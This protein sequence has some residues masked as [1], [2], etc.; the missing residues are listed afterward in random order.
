[1]P[2][3]DDRDNVNFGLNSGL[4]LIL[5]GFQSDNFTIRSS[6]L[7]GDSNMVCFFFGPNLVMGLILKI[8]RSSGTQECVSC[9]RRSLSK[10]QYTCSIFRRAD[11]F[12]TRKSVA[13]SGR[14]CRHRL[15]LA[16]VERH[17]V[18]PKYFGNGLYWLSLVFDQ[19]ELPL[20]SPVDSSVSV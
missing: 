16:N 8:D 3:P 1:M 12:T 19:A 6:R 7:A 18:T 10:Y 9:H 15:A 5:A 2:D 20:Q 11:G 17:G 13:A 4:I 14:R